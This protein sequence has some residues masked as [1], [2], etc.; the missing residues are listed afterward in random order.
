MML[1]NR[2]FAKKVVVEPG[3]RLNCYGAAAAAD[4]HRHLAHN[5]L[6]MGTLRT[7]AVSKLSR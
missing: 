1:P 2:H 6:G 3:N 5:T 7:G 4:A